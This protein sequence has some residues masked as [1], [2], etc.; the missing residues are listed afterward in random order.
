[1]FGYLAL[2]GEGLERDRQEQ[3]QAYYCGLCR[4]LGTRYGSACRLFLSNDMVFLWLLLSSLYEPEEKTGQSRCAPHPFRQRAYLENEVAD[5]CADMNIALAYHKCMD[6]WK[7]DRSLQGITGVKLIQKAYMQVRRKHPSLC[8]WIRDCLQNI[9]ELERND[10]LTPDEPAEWTAKMLGMIFR[11]REDYWA[12]TLQGMGE[13]MGRFIY[14]MDAYEDLQ[15]DMW[16]GRYNPLKEYAKQREYES[17]CEDGL[18][19]LAAECAQ[20]FETLPL[21]KDVDILRN[22]LYAGVWT[23]YHTKRKTQKQDAS[24]LKEDRA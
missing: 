21:T 9:A 15:S 4:A 3:Y 17:L 23:R 8:E 18:T 14:L 5:Y 7:D 10:R 24:A 20:V 12:D 16:R 6:D 2:S 13:A 11:Y 19:L 22:I 1:M